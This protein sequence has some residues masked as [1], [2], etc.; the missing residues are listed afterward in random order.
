MAIPRVL[1]LKEHGTNCEEGSKY[2]FEKAGARAEIVHMND[3]LANPKLMRDYQ[4]MMFP[5][6]FSHGDDTGSGL[7]WANR[8]RR[9]MD[10]V[11][12]F[13][14]DDKLVLGVCNGFQTLV[15]MGLLP[16]I[17]E[18]YGEVQAALLHNDSARYDCRWVDLSLSDRSPWTKGVG[19]ISLPIAHGEGKFYASPDFMHEIKK[20][21]LDVAK[22]VSGEISHSQGLD[23]NPNG[24]L[25]DI[26]GICDISGRV[27]GLMPH[28]ERAIDFT[29]R[30]DWTLLKEKYRR[31]GRDIPREGEGMEIFKNGVKYFN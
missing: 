17:N 8:M 13:V 30:P 27:F 28:P 16:A 25:E 12:E 21:G 19:R 31:Q 22:Y 5:G 10:D 18:R 26:A 15:N 1:V 3:L 4:I 11:Q 7:A 23:Y 6:G 2:A 20:K 24:S 14:L 29:Q 9:V